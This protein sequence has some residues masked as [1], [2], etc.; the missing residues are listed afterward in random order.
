MIIQNYRILL[1]LCPLVMLAGFIDSIAGGGGLI[2]L[3]AYMSCG[4]PGAYAL[5]TNKFGSFCGSTFA[6][7]NYIKTKNFDFKTLLF[8]LPAA[9]L[10]ST[11]GSRCALLLSDYFLEQILL[12]ATPVIVFLVL[13]DKNY[14]EK[15]LSLKKTKVAI[16]SVLIGLVVGFYDGFYGPGTGMF[17]QMGF[18]MLVGLSVK[19]SLGT[20]RVI[21]LTSNL[22]ALATFIINGT[23][24]YSIGIPC[25]ICSIIGN[26]LGSKLAIK[27]DVKIVKP[28]MLVVVALLFTK[29]LLSKFG[30]LN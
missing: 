19:K 28:M 26:Y 1:I 17:L 3:T 9:L 13:K 8:A 10:G 20:A 25:A 16:L 22:G 29:L 21:N 23:V 14:K 30:I 4:I 15:D 27:R 5:G 18:I 2:T 12:F 6:S 24:I 7:A 11:I